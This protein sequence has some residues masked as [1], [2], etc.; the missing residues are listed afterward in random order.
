MKIENEMIRDFVSNLG[1]K[2]NLE[3]IKQSSIDCYLTDGQ[4]YISICQCFTDLI[5]YVNGVKHDT[6]CKRGND[7]VVGTNFLS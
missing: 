4:D 6:F 5:V 2:D 1:F 3:I 7:W